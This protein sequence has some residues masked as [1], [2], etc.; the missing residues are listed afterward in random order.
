MYIATAVTIVV[1][2]FLVRRGREN[3]QPRATP[4]NKTATDAQQFAFLE[5]ANASECFCSPTIHLN[6]DKLDP[7]PETIGAIFGLRHVDMIRF[8]NLEDGSNVELVKYTSSSPSTWPL[9]PGCH[10]RVMYEGDDVVPCSIKDMFSYLGENEEQIRQLSM[11]FYTRIWKDN[12]N[13]DFQS[14]FVRSVKTPEEAADNQARWLIEM[15]GGP[16][17]YTEKYGSVPVGK[18]MLSRHSSA[19]RMTFQHAC[20]WLNYMNDSV[21]EVYGDD[22]DEVKLLLGLYWRHFFGFFSMSDEERIGIRKRALYIDT[23]ST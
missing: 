15:W 1:G 13:P 5:W 16:R 6:L 14:H 18:R 11:S 9:I 8:T 17:R 19:R 10:Y 20:T 22:N 21:S 7:S 2:I 3:S 23:L 12:A 4:K